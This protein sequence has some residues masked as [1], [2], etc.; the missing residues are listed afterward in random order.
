[1]EYFVD[2]RV[3]E[4]DLVSSGHVYCRVHALHSRFRGYLLCTRFT[5]SVKVTGLPSGSCQNVCE[6]F[7]LTRNDVARVF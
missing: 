7:S 1:M 5:L 6:V 4:G 2:W 3:Q